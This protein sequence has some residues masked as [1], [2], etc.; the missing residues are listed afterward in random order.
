M[1]SMRVAVNRELRAGSTI[2]MEGIS[3][4]DFL[5]WS[6]FMSVTGGRSLVLVSAPISLAIP[7]M[8]VL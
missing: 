8:L 4:V 5:D 3:K 6:I 7:S 2:F 1:F